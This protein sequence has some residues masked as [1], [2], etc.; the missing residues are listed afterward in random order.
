M[1]YDQHNAMNAITICLITDYTLRSLFVRAS[2]CL[3]NFSDV[4]ANGDEIYAVE[5]N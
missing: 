4:L 2:P 5:I 1:K 3:H